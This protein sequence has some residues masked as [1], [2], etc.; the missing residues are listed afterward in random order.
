MQEKEIRN[1]LNEGGVNELKEKIDSHMNLTH[2]NWFLI[3]LFTCIIFIGFYLTKKQSN[4]IQSHKKIKQ[5]YQ[6]KV[7]S[8]QNFVDTT[9]DYS[10]HVKPKKAK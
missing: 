5:F 9:L 7:D 3:W 2:R 8:L 6:E 4:P 1:A 10:S